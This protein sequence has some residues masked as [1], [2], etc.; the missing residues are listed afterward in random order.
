MQVT[1]GHTRLTRVCRYSGASDSPWHRPSLFPLF[2][3]PSL[4]AERDGRIQHNASTL[5]T[6]V[7]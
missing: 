2:L 3:V 4:L 7:L 5:E 1:K 6:P